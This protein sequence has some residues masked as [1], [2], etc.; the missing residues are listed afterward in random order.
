[1]TWR[2]KS[3]ATCVAIRDNN[4]HFFHNL[5]LLEGISIPFGTYWMRNDPLSSLRK[6][7]NLLPKDTSP[8]ILRILI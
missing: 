6:I 3:R 4:T 5:L 2:L 1:M 7:W 8:N